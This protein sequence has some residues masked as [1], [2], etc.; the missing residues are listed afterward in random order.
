MASPALLLLMLMMMS[1]LTLKPSA[2]GKT[3]EK[4]A[5]IA[6][7]PFKMLLDNPEILTSFLDLIEDYGGAVAG[8]ATGIIKTAVGNPDFKKLMQKMQSIQR[9]LTEV[10]SCIRVEQ[11]KHMY[12]EIELSINNAWVEH[13][14]FRDYSKTLKNV[15]EDQMEKHFKAI[16]IGETDLY[17][18]FSLIQRK[19]SFIER[20]YNTIVEETRCHEERIATIEGHVNQ[21]MFKRLFMNIHLYRYNND[22]YSKTKIVSNVQYYYHGVMDLHKALLL[23]CFDTD[24]TYIK[25]DF[26]Y[27][28]YNAEHT[29][30]R[31]M[32]KAIREYLSEKHFRYDW[33]VIVYETDNNVLTHITKHVLSKE[34]I[35]RTGPA[36][37]VAAARQLK[38]SH[39][40][41][42]NIKSEIEGCLKRDLRFILRCNSL[43]EKLGACKLL[44]KITGIHYYRFTSNS[45]SEE[46]N[47]KAE[48]APEGTDPTEPEE[49]YEYRG[50]CDAW[51][52]FRVMIKSDE[53]LLNADPCD[54]S[55]CQNGSKCKNLLAV[56][57]CECV[58]P[59]FGN[60]C[61]EVV[62][63]PEKALEKT[64]NNLVEALD[65]Q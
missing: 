42:P 61:E 43:Q 6:A 58:Y 38:G 40:K 46:T 48:S 45:D 10:K 34:F 41:V 9:A 47:R 15:P 8:A 29:K 65:L 1:S 23:K 31:K 44:V 17:S 51:S 62:K 64:M 5:H 50:R 52:H 20:V 4:I 59:Y 26:D 19:E 36:L 24:T 56:I 33:M 60:T 35:V 57:V 2:A 12:G 7:K 28:L 55:P 14:R 63:Y 13:E 53:E 30:P 18:L 32:A 37:T 39:T 16:S 22:D 54:S 27:K 49:S 21:L 25:Q 3:A 11:A